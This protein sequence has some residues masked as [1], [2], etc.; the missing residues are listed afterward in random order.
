MNSLAKAFQLH[1]ADL[2]S[3]HACSQASRNGL[4]GARQSE[5]A[6]QCKGE[7]ERRV[8]IDYHDLHKWAAQG[9]V[10]SAADVACDLR[11]GQRASWERRYYMIQLK[12][13]GKGKKKMYG[14][15]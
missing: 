15:E 11:S 7:R 12:R 2:R 6:V 5:R 8:A 1:S 9:C 13:S 4:G 3:V 10:P 14:V